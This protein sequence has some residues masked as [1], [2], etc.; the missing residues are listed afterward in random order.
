MKHHN[1]ILPIFIGLLFSFI[2]SGT[3]C[4]YRPNILVFLADDMGYGDS[5]V[6]N[7][8]SKIPMPNLDRLAEDGMVFTDFHTSASY[9]APSRYSFM[10]GNYQWR[11]LFPE[12]Q[13]DYKAGSQILHGQMSLADIVKT[14]GYHTAIFGKLH[15]GGEFYIENSSE[16][17]NLYTSSYQ[18][19]FG[20]GLIDGPLSYGFD[21]SFTLLR[22]IQRPPY[23][24]FENDQLVC[25]PQDL[26][27]WEVGIYGDSEIMEWGKG[28]GMPDYDS[29]AVGPDLTQKAID[30]IDQHHQMNTT[31]GTDTPFFLYYAAQSAHQPW[32]PPEYFYGT[33][34]R[35]VTGM[36]PHTDMIYEVDVALGKLLD[37]LE[38]R[39]LLDDTL[40]IFASDN[41]GKPDELIYGHDAVGGLRGRKGTIWEGGHRV[42]FVVRWGDG[43]LPGSMIPPGTTRSQLLGAQD[44]AATIAALIEYD[45][46]A[47]QAYDSF[48][49]LPVLLGEQSDSDPVRD[50]LI[51]EDFYAA[52]GVPHANNFV[53]EFFA[54]RMDQWK[55]ILNTQNQVI[56]LYDLDDDL[57][58]SHNLMNVSEHSDRIAY[59]RNRFIELHSSARTSPSSGLETNCSN[60]IDDDGDDL[61]DCY[62]PDCQGAPD[63]D[64]DPTPSASFD[65]GTEGFLYAD[66]TFNGTHWPAY[67]SGQYTASSGFN[68]SGGLRVTLGGVDGVDVTSG[69]SGGWSKTF[70]VEESADAWIDLRYRLVMNGYDADECVQVLVSIDGGEPQVLAGLCGRDTETGWQSASIS[71]YLSAGS[72]TLTIGG[73]NNKKT[74]PAETAEIYFD[75]LEIN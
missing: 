60:G 67:A 36:T 48:N 20:R 31:N 27:T 75:D 8:D 16:F 65:S 28:L 63:C 45:L 32:T 34:V 54:F 23:A 25:D 41:G 62:D 15:L 51:M 71:Q 22:G 42:P 61:I 64:A 73:F 3:V 29:S 12:G 52:S 6:Y 66:D 2:F 39:G 50:H 30:F 14:S 5:Q 11:G 7:P 13:W 37:E 49:F 59:M 26:I 38:S 74:G 44:I 33:P 24:Y 53:S 57:T 17:A 1:I 46:P 43:T 70:L 72:H 18:V 21:Y 68:G 55:L 58:E 35:D 10:T 56:G 4:A 69:M 9:C 40:I 19:D 47:D